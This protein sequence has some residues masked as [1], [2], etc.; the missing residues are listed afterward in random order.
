VIAKAENLEPRTVLAMITSPRTVGIVGI[1]LGVIAF[2]LALP[3]VAVR[4]APAPIALGVLAGAT[5]GAKLLVNFK[6]KTVRLIFLPVLGIVAI[7]MLLR[8]LG[9]G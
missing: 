5:I 2:W 9:I 3:P 4:S 8:G 1:A 7:E 6:N